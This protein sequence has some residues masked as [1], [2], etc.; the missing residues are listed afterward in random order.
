MGLDKPEYTDTFQR[1]ASYQ[2]IRKTQFTLKFYEE[3]LN[4]STIEHNI[5]DNSSVANNYDIFK[6]HRH[7]QSIFS[8]LTKKYNIPCMRDPCQWNFEGNN[9]V[10]KAPGN[11]G[12]I[13]NH[14]RSNK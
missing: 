14:H 5:T 6:E 12:V 11:Y 3:Y 2:V 7:D 1:M 9:G 8:L 4:L 13:I 10:S